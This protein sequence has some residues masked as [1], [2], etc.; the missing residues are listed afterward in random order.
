MECRKCNEE[1][2]LTE[3]RKDPSTKSGY[4]HTCKA[5]L[6]IAYANSPKQKEAARRRHI[7][8]TYGIDMKVYDQLYEQQGGKCAICGSNG[9]TVLYVDHCH[10]NS[11]VR[12]LLCHSCNIGLGMFKDNHVLLTAAIQYLKEKGQ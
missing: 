11:N 12:G 9:E 6:K 5:C 8:A 3:F 7:K 2:E 10:N 1:K 4:N